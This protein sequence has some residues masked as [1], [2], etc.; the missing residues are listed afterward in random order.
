[1]EI[2]GDAP[3]PESWYIGKEKP[4]ILEIR[5]YFEN[6]DD[7]K[8][9]C[10]GFTGKEFNTFGAVRKYFSDIFDEEADV[11]VGIHEFTSD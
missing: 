10:Y 11:Y 2:Y 5:E 3:I 8:D 7:L 4:N 1:L 9:Y 6:F